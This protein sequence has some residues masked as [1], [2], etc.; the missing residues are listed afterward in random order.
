[1]RSQA[2]AVETGIRGQPDLVIGLFKWQDIDDLNGVFF[3]CF[4]LVDASLQLP[5]N[6]L[7]VHLLFIA[8]G[9]ALAIIFA[10]VVID[11]QLVHF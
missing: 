7:E 4:G 1:V 9:D 6:G 11:N 3:V 2:Y 10:S 8:A 5:C